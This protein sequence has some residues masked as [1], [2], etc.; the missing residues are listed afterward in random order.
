MRSSIARRLGVATVLIALAAACNDTPLTVGGLLVGSWGGEGFGLEIAPD[1]ASAV[2]TCAHGSLDTPI[3]LDADGG[4]SAQGEYVREV[5]PAALRNPA[6]YVGVL[7][8]STLTLSVIVTDTL[9][10][11]GTYTVGPFVGTRDGVPR[12]FFCQ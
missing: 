7:T 4:F 5:G 1:S 10:Q 6:R 2:F 9:G 11:A 8:G 12:V 3:A